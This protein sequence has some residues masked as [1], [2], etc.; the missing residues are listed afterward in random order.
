MRRDVWMRMIVCTVHR[1]RTSETAHNAMHSII[2]LAW[3]AQSVARIQR[4]P[5]DKI[6]KLLFNFEKH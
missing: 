3:I 1:P 5:G 4:P 6:Y 2:P